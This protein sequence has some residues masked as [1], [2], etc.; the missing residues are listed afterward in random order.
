MICTN[1][2]FSQKNSSTKYGVYTVDNEMYLSG[3]QVFY[4]LPKNK[5]IVNVKVKKTEII[6]GPYA[7]Y[8]SKYLNISEGVAAS[9]VVYYDISDIQIK[10][11]SIADSSKF[12][13]INNI[14]EENIPLINLN[15][16]GVIICYNCGNANNGYVAYEKQLIKQSAEEIEYVFTD[17][18]VKSF[19]Q[20]QTETL[21][22][23][24]STDTGVVKVPYT[25]TTT[26]AT[27]E[28]QNAEQA[29]AFVRKI[30]KR[31]SKLL[32]GMADEVIESDSKS[33]EIRIKKL[34]KLENE[35][36]ELF[37]GKKI[38]SYQNYC[39]DF[40]PSEN[41]SEEQ[42]N[43]CWFSNKHG[44]S[45]SK[46]NNNENDLLPLSVNMITKNKLPK[47]S[48][49]FN[50]ST[51]NNSVAYGL[52]Y[53]IPA[54]TSFIIKWNNKVLLKQLL[55]INQKGE[56]LALPDIY[57][58]DKKFSIEY[59]PETGAIKNIKNIMDK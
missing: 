1:Y 36:L 57:I 48:I 47:A 7:Q 53:R 44:V 20:E 29:A 34:N 6:Q 23:N 37:L 43:I 26:K 52:Y 28:E 9:D 59:Y 27:S 54:Q 56:V 10:K 46:T 49:N 11:Y 55:N 14:D 2:V 30:R 4:A 19:L 16:D 33:L 40:D 42:K 24:V 5:I 41:L 15:A 8:A 18:G 31:R 22:K 45:F 32:F 39:F 13:V 12:F 25:K 3:N 38:I 50:Q 21:F 58:K 35:Y 51:K 17:L